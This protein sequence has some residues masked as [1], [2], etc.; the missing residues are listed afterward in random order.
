MSPKKFRAFYKP[1]LDTPDGALKF[2]QKEINDDLLFVYDEDICYPF[3]IPF[4]DNDW[5]VQQWTGHNDKNNI[6]IYEGDI[7]YGKNNSTYQVKW[8][9]TG[10]WL[11]HEQGDLLDMYFYQ[12]PNSENAYSHLEII[13]NIF[14]NPKL[15]KKK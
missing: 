13:G 15:M 11:Y 7:L 1:D 6:E 3:H 8:G 2:E 5:I 14:E 4:I 10:W 9:T 12:M